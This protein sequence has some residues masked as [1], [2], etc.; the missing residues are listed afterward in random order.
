M[1]HTDFLAIWND[2]DSVDETEYLRWLTR[3]H[4]QEC[5]ATRGLV[6]VRVFRAKSETHVQFLIFY[7][8]QPDARIPEAMPCPEKIRARLKNFI[9][10]EGR[11]VQE[12]GEGAGGYVAC[13]FIERSDLPGYREAA[14][15]IANADR[16]AATRLFEA[17]PPASETH[18][19]INAARAGDHSFEAMLL[20]EALDED[21]LAAGLALMG[22]RQPTIYREIF[23]F[24][25]Q[26]ATSA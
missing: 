14:V 7:R 1:N 9:R 8:L 5:L 20:I 6:S 13:V 18:A 12:S 17:D 2:L 10:G 16:I 3:E 23:R 26:S 21:E 24:D 15:E 19:D 25:S 22:V 4:A 11:I